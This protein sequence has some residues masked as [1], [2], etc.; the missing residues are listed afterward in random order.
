MPEIATASRP[1]TSR[2]R[3]IPAS[4]AAAKPMSPA[5]AQPDSPA[6][7]ESA[8]PAAELADPSAQRHAM[9]AEAA[10]YIAEA[11]G[12]APSQ[13]LDDWLIAEREIDLL[14]SDGDR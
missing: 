13:E 4:R 3:N 6:A 8:A 2:A 14:L 12:F 9:I 11:R 10:F 1:R 5:A 7:A